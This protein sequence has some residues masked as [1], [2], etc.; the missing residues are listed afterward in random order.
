MKN[1]RMGRQITHRM[2]SGQGALYRDQN[3]GISI[4]RASLDVFQGHCHMTRDV[5]EGVETV[6]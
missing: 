3:F 4:M 2:C 6:S 1:Y 5:E